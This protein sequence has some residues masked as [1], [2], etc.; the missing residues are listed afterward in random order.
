MVKI[1]I[2][3]I[4]LIPRKSWGRSIKSIARGKIG[5]KENMVKIEPKLA[6]RFRKAWMEIKEREIKR[7]RHRC[8]MCG[9]SGSL[10]VHEVWEYDD[11]TLTQKLKGYIVLC[12]SC[13][14]VYHLGFAGI[15]GRMDEVIWH[16]IEVNKNHGVD[17]TLEQVVMAISEVLNQWAH[18]SEKRWRIDVSKERDLGDLIKTANRL[19]NEMLK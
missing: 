7:A 17:L 1:G 14:L 15:L 18:R 13:H 16:I 12:D 19:L 3:D 8:E 6:K 11:S 5:F 4:E 9:E 2:F 10:H